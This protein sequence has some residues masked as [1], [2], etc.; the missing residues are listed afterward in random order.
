[1]SDETVVETKE[2]AAE[3]QVVEVD[4][5]EA[6]AREQGWVN[7]DEWV[8]Q[9]KDPNEHRSAKEFKE[10]GEIYRSLH[11]T[12]R[13]LKQTQAALNVLQRQHQFV[14]EKAHKKAMDDLKRERRFAMKEGDADLLEDVEKEMEEKELEARAARQAMAQAAAASQEVT[15]TEFDTFLQRNPW[16]AADQDLRDEADAIGFVYL[17]KGGTKDNLL[18]HVETKIKQKYPEK[19]GA[20][21]RGAP[22]PTAN[23]DRTA[24]PSKNDI[25]LDE[26]ETKIMNDLVRS[27]EMTEAQYKAALKQAKGIK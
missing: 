15:S 21:K 10:R 5:V 26:F 13:E 1:M 2:V 22:A 9:G 14:F 18:K 24:R 23:G 12:R 4:P 7:N 3:V 19:F 20:V 11:S 16:Y 25:Q 8:A 17:N 27:G 6:E